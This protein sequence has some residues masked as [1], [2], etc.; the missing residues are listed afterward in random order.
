M[1]KF[2]SPTY[3]NFKKKVLFL[4]VLNKHNIFFLKIPRINVSVNYWEENMEEIHQNCVESCKGQ[5]LF[6]VFLV[7]QPLTPA[8][9]ISY[10]ILD[11]FLYQFVF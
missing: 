9:L 6:N 7:G 1:P 5:T 3:V 8:L 11:S 4:F 2:K 10:N